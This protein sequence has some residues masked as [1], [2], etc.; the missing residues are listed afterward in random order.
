M[1]SGSEGA[2][3]TGSVSRP[4]PFLSGLYPEQDA[5]ARRVY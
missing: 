4:T 1:E 5:K 3:K 2:T